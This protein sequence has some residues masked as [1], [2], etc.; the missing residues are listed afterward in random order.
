MQV[1]SVNNIKLSSFGNEKAVDKKDT[2]VVSSSEIDKKET[3][4]EDK[5][6][7]QAQ[8]SKNELM[9]GVPMPSVAQISK[10]QSVQKFLGG[11]TLAIGAFGMLSTFSS[12]KW[13]RGLFT[14]PVGGVIALFGA[15]M[16]KVAGAFDKLKEASN[17]QAGQQ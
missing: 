9:P 2:G 16:I 4:K 8:A 17:S 13:V 5:F 14:I 15:N 7:Q 12:K 10:M 3:L 11:L 1:N 6:Q